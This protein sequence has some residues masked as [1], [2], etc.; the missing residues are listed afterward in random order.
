MKYTKSQ[1]MKKIKVEWCENFIRA[2]FKKHVP[3]GGGVYTE[4]FWNAAEKSGLWERGIYKTPMSEALGN[5]TKVEAVH[6]SEGNF[7][8]HVFKLL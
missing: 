7:L 3:D 1:L 2:F 4:C 8:Y 6:D 5:L